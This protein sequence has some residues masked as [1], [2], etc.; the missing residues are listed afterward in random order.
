VSTFYKKWQSGT[1]VYLGIHGWGGGWNTFEA[2]SEFL[3]ENAVLYA[4]DLPGFGKTPSLAPWTEHAM[5]AAII[6]V[7][8][9]IEGD[10]TLIGN[11]SG[12]IFGMLAALERPS[13]FR[14]LVL[15]EP[16][17]FFPWYFRLLTWP[18]LGRFFY[19]MA[20]QNPLGR[21]ITNLSLSGRRT[22]DTDLTESFESLNHDAVFSHLLLLKGV[23]S[24][25]RFASLNCPIDLIVGA[26]SF[27]AIRESVTRWRSIWK[28]A[29]VQVLDDG[30]HLPLQEAT[31][32]VAR[33]TF[34]P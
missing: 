2:L 9:K 32:R 24:Y 18:V 14:R 13:R 22:S 29:R 8:D 30:A 16:F 20:F 21:L 1:D 11:C 25:T 27:G 15:L 31:Q 23:G 34:I 5:T 33:I 12:A 7:V 28:Q 26:G 3:P 17:A 6:E 10:I 19:A 4:L